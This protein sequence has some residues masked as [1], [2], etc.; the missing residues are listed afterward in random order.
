M[1][2]SRKFWHDVDFAIRSLMLRQLLHEIITESH[3]SKLS[4]LKIDNPTDSLPDRF[5]V[6]TRY[7]EVMMKRFRNH[8]HST[9]QAGS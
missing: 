8:S 4:H 5:L 9:P 7:R 3:N 6:L 1:R 2:K